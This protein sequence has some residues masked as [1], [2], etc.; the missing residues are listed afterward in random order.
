MARPIIFLGFEGVLSLAPNAV[1]CKV[2][3]TA[4][5]RKRLDDSLL[6][7]LFC[8]DACENL[9]TLQ[10]QH[11]AQFV[12]TSIW[13]DI[14][15]E[16]ELCALLEKCELHFITA[17]LHKHWRI[18]FDDWAFKFEEIDDWLRLYQRR[19]AQ[20]IIID[21]DQERLWHTLA[22]H[23]W[24]RTVSCVGNHGFTRDRLKEASQFFAG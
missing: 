4:L 1:V 15:L 22:P 12:I 17:N 3:N 11:N 5:R 9:A 6:Q 7:S 18:P 14:L 16:E 23:V 21:D 20:F 24:S 2:L 10:Q 19:H 8:R 13:G